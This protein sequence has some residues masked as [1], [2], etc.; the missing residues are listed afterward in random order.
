M[1][2]SSATQSIIIL[3]SMWKRQLRCGDYIESQ[4][5]NPKYGVKGNRIVTE[6][7]CAICYEDEDI[8]SAE[9]ICDKRDVG[10]KNQLLV[11]RY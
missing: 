2:M 5:Y 9:E 4:Y 8:V 1:G 10:G 7:I 3:V 11:C 6:D